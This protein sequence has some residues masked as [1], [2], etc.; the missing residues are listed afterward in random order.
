MLTVKVRDRDRGLKKLKRNLKNTGKNFVTVGIFGERADAAHAGTEKS[1]VEI[2]GFHEFG[3]PT[4]KPRSYIR[5]TVDA[6]K[7]RIRQLQKRLAEQIIKRRTTEAQGLNLIGVFLQGKMQTRIQAGI[8]P[9]L[10]DATIK[11]K[12]VQGKKGTTPLID[13]GQLIQSITFAVMRGKLKAK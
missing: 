2:A 5:A 12:T 1:N 4:I 8:A 9:P 6:E 10:E 13:T 11:R 7:G 3:T